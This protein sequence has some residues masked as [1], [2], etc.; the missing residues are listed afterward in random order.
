MLEHQVALE[1]PVYH[2]LKGMGAF[3]ALMVSETWK[4]FHILLCGFPLAF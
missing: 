4:I 3:M 2:L 1:H